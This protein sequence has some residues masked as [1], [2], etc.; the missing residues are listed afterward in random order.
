MGLRHGRADLTGRPSGGPGPLA[1][2]TAA[3]MPPHEQS[4]HEKPLWRNGLRSDTRGM[5]STTQPQVSQR[6]EPM[7]GAEAQD[8]VVRPM[9]VDDDAE[10]AAA[11]EVSNASKRHQRPWGKTWSLREMTIQLRTPS[12]VERLE[13]LVALV[14]GKVA[15]FAMLWFPLLDNTQ[16][17]W[18]ELDVD[19]ALRRRGA[20]GAL[21][22]RMI[23]RTREEGRRT[24]LV[25]FN[26]PDDSRADHPFVRFAEQHGFYLRQHRD[27]P[28]SST[29][30]SLPSGW[31]SSP[32]ARPSA[33]RAI[34]SS[35]TG[36]RCRTP[37]CRPTASA[38]TSS[39]ST[40]PPGRWTSRRSPSP[41]DLRRGARAHAGAGADDAAHRGHRAVR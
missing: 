3:R 16:F 34:G 17:T 12:S 29:C 11:H 2:K 4:P 35:S 1:R 6:N 33:T 13:P 15:G 26:V 27:P 9:D 39:P 41:R 14:D 18:A 38:G 28:R 24:V 25:E 22:E 5:N 37:C 30:P 32:P 36:P 8:V 20:G 31:W 21:L 7:T 10:V 19:P 40:P 23:A